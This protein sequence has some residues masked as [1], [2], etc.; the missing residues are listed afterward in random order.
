MRYHQQAGAMEHAEACENIPLNQP[1]TSERTGLASMLDEIKEKI[2][3]FEELASKTTSMRPENMMDDGVSVKRSNPVP[4]NEPADSNRR[5]KPVLQGKSSSTSSS[6]ENVS[7]HEFG[8]S[9]H[10]RSTARVI[11]SRHSPKIPPFTGQGDTW[12]VWLNRFNVA[13]RWGWSTEEKLNEL[14]PRLQGQAGDFVY[15]QLNPHVRGSFKMLTKELEC[16]FRKVETTG[17]FRTQFSHRRQKMGESVEIY[18]AELKRIYDKAYPDRDRKTRQE[19]LL[20]RFLEGLQDDNARH[21]VEYVKSP[22]DVDEAVYEVVNF[23]Y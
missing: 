4:F 23:V 3:A 5:R 14:L 13:Q 6:D 1:D 10:S 8:I 12:K 22:G 16:R 21:L 9:I 15:G 7:S 17:T 11:P 20:R 18:A 19:D 2:A